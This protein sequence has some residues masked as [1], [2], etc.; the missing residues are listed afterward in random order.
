[1]YVQGSLLLNTTKA[2]VIP[3]PAI[4]RSED[5]DYVFRRVPS[6]SSEGGSASVRLE[7]VKVKV[8]NE[9]QGMT[10]IVQGIEP[11][12]DVIVQGALVLEGALNSN[13]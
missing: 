2:V 11:G 6:A 8:G 10:A 12:D 1:M 3:T 5:S 9:N 4:I 7:K 13:Q